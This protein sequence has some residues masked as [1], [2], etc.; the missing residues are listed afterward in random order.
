MYS[1]STTTA[2]LSNKSGLSRFVGQRVRVIGK[3][4]G[5][6]PDGAF[7]RVMAPDGVEVRCRLNSQ[8][9]PSGNLLVVLVTGVV[10]Q[11]AGTVS[12]DTPILELGSDIDLALL[13][14]AINLQ[15]AKPFQH[16]FLPGLATPAF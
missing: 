16:L 3:I 1:T 5:L 7:L 9:K 13:N 4:S 2:V 10:E 11:D 12:A 8:P 14:E 15:F 6:S